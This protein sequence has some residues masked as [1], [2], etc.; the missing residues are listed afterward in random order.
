MSDDW[1][2][3]F[4]RCAMYDHPHFPFGPITLRSANI[5]EDYWKVERGKI[6]TGL[7][8]FKAL[9]EIIDNL[10]TDEPK[11]LGAIFYGK[12][13]TG[14]TSA[15]VIVLKEAITRGGQTFM[16]RTLK[17]PDVSANR[18]DRLTREGIP[19][20]EMLLQRQF[21]LLDDLGQEASKSYGETTTVLVEEIIRAR[22]D[23]DLTT[24]I[25][26]NLSMEKLVEMYGSISTILL[27]P[28]RFRHI[29]VGGKFWRKGE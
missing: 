2:I 21:L 5:G 22:Y 12:Q 19:I 10:H 3:Q 24:Y 11:G 29:A 26:T 15:G 18:D 7:P 14:K 17:L 4:K 13:G 20:W 8:Y 6:P 16:F 27:D 9:G 28:S 23:A 1:I 25:T